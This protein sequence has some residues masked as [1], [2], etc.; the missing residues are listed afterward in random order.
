MGKIGLGWTLPNG[1][2]S[3]ERRSTFIADVER[4]LDLISGHF[5]SVWMADHLEYQ[6]VDMLEGWTSIAYFA[7][8]HPQLRFGHTVICQ[9]FR[10]PALLAKMGATLQ[11]LTGGRLILGIGAGWNE[12]EYRA[13]GYDFP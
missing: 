3:V 9:G 5:E 4:G 13:Y 11:F 12:E 2:A 1:A 6:D 10:N 8:S 7:A